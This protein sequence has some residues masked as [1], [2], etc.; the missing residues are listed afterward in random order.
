MGNRYLA[1]LRDSDWLRFYMEAMD[2]LPIRGQRVL[3]LR[4]GA[5]ILS[6]LAAKLGASSVTG[7]EHL[8]DMAEVAQAVA[9]R[10]EVG[11]VVSIINGSSKRP[12]PKDRRADVIIAEAFGELLL[13]EGILADL[14]DARRRFAKPGARVIPAAGSQYIILMS[15]PSL[16][17]MTK[18][19]CQATQI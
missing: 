11:S 8:P 13:G 1:S 9:S 16:R 5:G 18:M 12:L 19:P 15:S 2:G 6:V 10:N 4:A 7:I 14:V 17:A 3:D